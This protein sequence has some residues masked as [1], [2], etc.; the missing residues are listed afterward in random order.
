AP[1]RAPRCRG[2]ED[3]VQDL[4]W[5]LR[6]RH[7]DPATIELRLGSPEADLMVELF[8]VRGDKEHGIGVMLRDVTRE[9]ELI[10]AKD[11]LVSIVSHELRG[12]LSNIIGF[13][14]LLLMQHKGNER[15]IQETTIV[16]DGGRR[17][18]S[19]IDDSLD[20]PRIERGA[21]RTDRRMVELRAILR[22]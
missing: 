2:G 17:L 20:L 5:R 11:E 22:R 16:A 18:A 1:L 15:A 7:A 6:R 4:R 10:R 21:M 12:P 3:D 9:R 14:D 8:P 13:A 19:I